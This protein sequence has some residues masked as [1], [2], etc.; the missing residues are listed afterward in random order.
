MRG[1]SQ[2]VASFPFHIVSDNLRFVKIESGILMRVA[3]RQF[4]SYP[5]N[6]SV[7]MISEVAMILVVCVGMA[8][9]VL[10]AVSR[11]KKSGTGHVRLVGSIGLVDAK[12]DPHGTVLIKGE[13]WRACLK[14]GIGL[15]SG[16]KVK[17]VGTCDHLLLVRLH[18][19]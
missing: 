10:A 12:L 3:Q 7:F 18:D 15:V 16:S 1:D 19:Q 17:V 9:G 6:R 8:A 4:L 11:Y 5:F 14:D 13:L 2:W